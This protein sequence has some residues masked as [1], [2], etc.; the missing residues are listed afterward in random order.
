MSVLARTSVTGALAFVACLAAPACVAFSSDGLA[1]ANGVV[2]GAAPPGADDAGATLQYDARADGS[3]G[4]FS[5]CHAAL[6]AGVCNPDDEHAA[7]CIATAT[8]DAGADAQASA[9][10]PACR[11]TEQKSA[12]APACVQAGRGGDGDACQSA[13]DCGA[14]Y[15]CVGSPGRCRHYCCEE[16]ACSPK[17]DGGLPLPT[18]F[19]DVQT[20]LSA[21]KL[22]VPVCLPVQPCKLLGTVCA[23]GQ[24][25]GIVDTSSGTTSCVDVGPAKVGESCNS[26]HCGANLACLGGPGARVC[27]QLCNPTSRNPGE[28][29]T[30]TTCKTPWAMLK[31]AGVGICD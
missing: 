24:T 5:L 9:G 1:V 16:A 31:N 6:G 2:D 20:Q 29:P 10:S 25:C 22:H 14:G 4:A 28:C 23:T 15:E 18:R 30:G 13:T 27:V 7:G 21:P 17:A 19:C 26:T 3:P 12:A 8:P 11:V